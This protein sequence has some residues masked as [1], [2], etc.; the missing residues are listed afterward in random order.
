MEEPLRGIR[1]RTVPEIRQAVDRSIRTINRTGS[2]NGNIILSR[3]IKEL[4]TALELSGKSNIQHSVE[5]F[6][7]KKSVKVDFGCQT[8]LSHE[9][10]LQPLTSS[11]YCQ[12]SDLTSF[13]LEEAERIINHLRRENEDQK[14][15]LG[16]LR[17]QLSKSMG[18]QCGG[19]VGRGDGVVGGMGIVRLPPN[20]PGAQI[21][22][23]VGC[24][25]DGGLSA[26]NTRGNQAINHRFP[27]LQSQSFWH[28]SHQQQ[29]VNQRVGT[30]GGG[31]MDFLPQQN[32][33]NGVHLDKTAEVI[34]RAVP[35][36]LPAL[37][38]PLNPQHHHQHQYHVFPTFQNVNR[39]RHFHNNNGG[40]HT[41][42]TVVSQYGNGHYRREQKGNGRGGEDHHGGERKYRGRGKDRDGNKQ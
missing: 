7:C 3:K 5:K 35:R 18:R 8:E 27:P 25:T 36:S 41:N 32:S 28:H 4:E 20:D 37:G 24:V 12:E 16:G 34:G 29:H 10:P 39:H 40:H 11:G 21:V 22:G 14:R 19:R 30:A 9:S 26:V 17:I 13:K 33:C 1:F 6:D 31:G 38:N 2:A 42:G 15:E 23:L